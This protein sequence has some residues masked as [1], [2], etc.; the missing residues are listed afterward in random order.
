MKNT[1]KYAG[2]AA[3]TL[4]A[5]APVVAPVVG[6]T[7]SI[8]TALAADA[9]GERNKDKDIKSAADKYFAEF[10]NQELASDKF[11][12]LTA[13]TTKDRAFVPDAKDNTKDGKITFVKYADFTAT[14]LGQSVGTPGSVYNDVLSNEKNNVSVSVSFD[15]IKTVGDFDV[16]QKALANGSR[17]SFKVTISLDYKDSEGS[18]INVAH[19]ATYTNKEVVSTVTTKATAKYTTPY[20]IKTGSSV[21]DTKYSTSSDLKITD[22]DG[23]ALATNGVDLQGLFTSLNGVTKAVNGIKA[24]VPSSTT[25]DANVAPAT[26]TKSDFTSVKDGDFQDTKFK[27][28]GKT[29]YQPITVNFANSSALGEFMNAYSDKTTTNKDGK[30]TLTING[31]NINNIVSNVSAV[32]E[33]NTAVT[34]VREIKVVDKTTTNPTP[35]GNKWTYTDS[36][37]VVIVN[38][39]VVATLHN[40]KNELIKNRQLASNS[41]W[42]TGKYRVNE[43]GVKQYQVSTHEWVSS[44]DV[45]LEDKGSSSNGFFTEITKVPNTHVVSLGGITGYVYTLFREDGSVV[46]Q[47]HLASGTA[48]RVDKVAK[49]A[50]GNTYYRVSTNE[51]VIQGDGVS[52]K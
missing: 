16:L 13:L 28:A 40:D 18:Q 12:D 24:Y 50:D 32:D 41:G 26:D 49:D 5:V 6:S 14:K 42:I 8:Q 19:S 7:T 2:I 37:G 17:D 44:T 4:L 23:K 1:I 15:G 29:Y 25:K 20:E 9:S 22:Q 3:A 45:H 35:D 38:K 51:W 30:Y 43:N 52:Y 21:Y 46:K 31:Q 47:R 33:A 39:D 27:D 11:K 48:W 10:G 36:K 34:V